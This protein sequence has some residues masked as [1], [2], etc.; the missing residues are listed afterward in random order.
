MKLAVVIPTYK[1]HIPFLKN[2][3]DSITKQTCTPELVVVRASSC[4]AE[5]S[6]ALADISAMAWPFTLTVLETDKVQHTGQNKNEGVA[7]VPHDID[8]ISF[9]DSDDLMHPR[10]LEFVKR[11]ISEGY[12]VVCHGFVNDKDAWNMNEEPVPV[13]ES[14]VKYATVMAA[15]TNEYI[16]IGRVIFLDENEDEVDFTDGPLTL[17][18]QCFNGYPLDSRGHQD[19]VFFSGLHRAGYKVVNLNMGLM[20]YTPT[21]DGE[22]LQRNLENFLP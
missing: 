15:F 7:A 14:Y 17:R 3:L 12:D 10:R 8:I 5:C 4:D 6:R 22:R 1:Y 9:F 13:F 21:S 19:C 20:V 16:K 18:R 2:T 11:Y